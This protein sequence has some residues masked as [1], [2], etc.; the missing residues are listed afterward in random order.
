MKIV[1]LDGYTLNPGDLSWSR[2]QEL[3]CCVVYDRTPP[4][5][6]IERADDAEI[7]LTNKTILS[8][9]ILEK[10]RKL[11]YI[12]VL[13]TGYNVV[14]IVVARER[15]I[16]VTNVPNYGTQS[17][18]QAVFAHLLNLAHRYAYHAQTVVEGRWC[19]SKDFCYWDFPLV[20][21]SGLTMGI[22]GYGRIGQNVAAIA[23]VFGMKVLASNTS[24]IK[25]GTV[26]EVDIDTLF[27]RSDVITLHCP[28]KPHN[29]KMV[30]ARLLGL[31]KSTAFL[32]NTSRGLLIDEAALA[33]SLNSEKLAGAGLDVL[34]KE[35]PDP[36]NPL[37][38]AKN[39]FISPHIAWATQSARKR[40]LNIAI[41]N[42][43]A[44]L[45]DN[46]MNRVN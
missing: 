2:L 18:A 23:R 39:C 27:A 1:V 7:V 36:A 41:D 37:L 20:E 31:M 32:I 15:G 26:T 10:L 12:G 13:A 25:D 33:Q 45:N 28:L 34:S 44:F 40:L 8:K 11:K 35:P 5:M 22:V 9:A 42:V 16:I 38:K 30:N 3:G 24:P 46:V 21:L 19:T 14:D 29:E 6:V 43:K 4:D 17:V